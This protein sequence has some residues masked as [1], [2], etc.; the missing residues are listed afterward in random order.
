[1][2]LKDLYVKKETIEIVDG[3]TK[4]PVLLR[5]MTQ[6]DIEERN[7]YHL[8]AMREAVKYAQGLVDGFARALKARSLDE[9]RTIIFSRETASLD[10]EIGMLDIENEDKITDEDVKAKRKDE[11]NKLKEKIR[12]ETDAVP[13]EQARYSALLYILREAQIVR[14][15][16]IMALPTVVAIAYEPSPNADENPVRMLSMDAGAENYI[17]ELDPETIRQ[18]IEKTEKFREPITNSDIMGVVD[19]P[20][21]LLFVPLPA[22]GV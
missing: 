19:N 10:Y 4:I 2:K 22:K 3:D 6:A 8:D 9:I 13:E 14:F 18:L 11:L 1:M 7:E 12:T 21:F 17:K 16:E 15:N 5:S 20:N